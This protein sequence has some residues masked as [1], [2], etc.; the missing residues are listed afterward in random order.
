MSKQFCPQC[1]DLGLR[2][3]MWSRGSSTTL[4]AGRGEYWDEDGIRHVHDP[5]TTKT[6]YQCSEGHD[7]VVTSKQSCPAGDL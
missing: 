2:S 1:Q 3:S 4:L 6:A 5:N 7:W